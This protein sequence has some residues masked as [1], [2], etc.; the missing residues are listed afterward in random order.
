MTDARRPLQTT[1]LGVP[2]FGWLDGRSSS[3]AALVGNKKWLTI[4]TVTITAINPVYQNVG[5]ISMTALRTGRFRGRLTGYVV[6]GGGAVHLLYGAMSHGNGVLTPDYAQTPLQIVAAGEETGGNATVALTI[7]F[8]AN[9][10][11]AV[12]GSTTNINALFG[13]DAS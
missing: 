11:T 3:I 8:P 4:P 6:N 2:D 9:G 7:D 13:S 5:A 12:V 1:P 10:F